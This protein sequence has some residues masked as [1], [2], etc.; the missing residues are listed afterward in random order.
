MAKFLKNISAFMLIGVFLFIIITFL[1]SKY[2]DTYTF[3][4]LAAPNISNNLSFNDKL[5]FASQKESECL[6]I[7]SSITLNNLHSQTVIDRLQPRSYLNLA[8]WG[9]TTK[10]TFI[11]FKIYSEMHNPKTVIVMSNIV[12]YQTTMLD[13]NSSDTKNYLKNKN[14]FLFHIKHF[15][16]KYYLKN[17]AFYEKVK[18]TRKVYSS[19]DYDD[20]GG[21]NFDNEF[22]INEKRW[23]NLFSHIEIDTLNYIYLDS[24]CRYAKNHDI[25]LIY[26]QSPFR[27]GL[28]DSINSP[29][30]EKHTKLIDTII[31]KNNQIFIDGN[32]Q[33]WNDTLFTDAIHFNLSGAKKFTEFCMNELLLNRQNKKYNIDY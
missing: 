32:K 12:D 31:T 2:D 24:L 17:F 16:L 9:L 25:E 18:N 4:Y 27:K 33:V 5:R 7:G 14:S 3:K 15:E 11:L 20:Y 22:Q 19:L 8:S 6:S 26:L 21:V 10:I 13:F 1:Y 28:L 23:N 29:L 30:L